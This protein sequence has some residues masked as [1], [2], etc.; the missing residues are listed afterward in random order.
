MPA[1]VAF[2]DT[3]LRYEFGNHLHFSWF[4]IKP[5]ELTGQHIRGVI[6]EAAF[7]I[8][9]THYREALTG[10]KSTFWG[11]IPYSR[12]GTRFIHGTAAP[13][14][15]NGGDI[16]GIVVLATDLT[17][18]KIMERALDAI[19]LRNKTILD[20]A[21][22]GIVTIDDKGIIQSCN[23]SLLKLFGYREEELIG[24]N[25]KIL[26]PSPHAENHDSYLQHYLDTG[27]KRIIGIGREVT[28]KRKDGS[29]FPM[30]LSVGEFVENGRRFFTGFTRDITERKNAEYEARSHL[31][32][33][34]HL[35]RLDT[36]LHLASNISHEVNQPLTAIVTMAQALLRNLRS[37]R[38]DRKILES[39]LEKIVQQGSRA[40]DIIHEIRYYYSKGEGNESSSHDIND[41]I[42]DVLLLLE[43]DIVQNNI[44]IE[45]SF[46][47]DKRF[48]DINRIQIEQVILNLVQNAIE[49]MVNIDG[50]RILLI[51]TSGPQQDF[52]GIRVSI[53]DNGSGLPTETGHIFDPFFT[54]KQKGM[55]QGLAICR[56][57]IEAHGGTISANPNHGQGAVFSFTLPAS[58]ADN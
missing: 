30:D 41:I 42:S 25:I 3:G 40:S 48:V 11:E 4:G 37:G 26:M 1:L 12:G 15:T 39:T 33:L 9:E 18:Q 58:P 57:I 29:E 24:E 22:D 21:V 56:T 35:S 14:S 13:L 27:E 38:D 8:L 23:P 16:D 45:T 7:R 31:N 53:E 2:L 49:A 52:P 10:Q 34:A 50:E 51:K 46:D 47:K 6:G 28:G 5:A 55:G 17:E 44:R 19:T 32:E 43:H 54:T 20:T 36:N